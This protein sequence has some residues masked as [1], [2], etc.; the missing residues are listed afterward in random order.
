V[1]SVVF[2]DTHVVV[3]LAA[4]KLGL[5]TAPARAAIE[6]AEQVRV[7]P[8]VALELQYLREIER[9]G[10]APDE[11]LL[12]VAAGVGAKLADFSFRE[13]AAASATLGWTR[14]PFDRLIVGHAQA[15]SGALV[16]KDETIR[17]HYARAVW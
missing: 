4:G 11:V 10:V 8:M 17:A 16:T 2:L 1:A 12:T 9:L 13:V 3:W 7:S 15:A 6:T 5:L 14:D